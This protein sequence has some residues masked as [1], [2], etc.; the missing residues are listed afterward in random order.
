MKADGIWT[1]MKAIY[2]FVGGTASTHK[3]NLTD[4]RDLDAAF[5][6]VFNGGWTHSS[7]GATPN[8]TNGYA[9]TKLNQA[10]HLTQTNGELGGYFRTNTTGTY[11]DMGCHFAGSDFALITKL[12]DNNFYGRIATLDIN[13]NYQPATT[14]GLFSIRANGT[15]SAKFIRNG[16]TQ[17]TKATTTFAI[18]SLN[19]G[20]GSAIAST[21]G[22]Y[23][24]T[25]Q[26][27]FN[28]ISDSLTDTE[29]ANLYTRVQAF[30]T[31]LSRQV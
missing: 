23:F 10:T 3:W 24:S 30:Q 20:I 29:A 1:K 14:L 2:P 22:V 18:E 5:R 6:L 7:T 17:A 25:R 4:P 31:S 16:T 12:G 27:A 19:I 11:V 9:D 15:N 26:T 8:G 21:G 13:S 28:Y